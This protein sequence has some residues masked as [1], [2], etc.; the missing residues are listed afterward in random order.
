MT[1]AALAAL[2]LPLL[3]STT[4]GKDKSESTPPAQNAPKRAVLFI[5]ADLRG[6]VAPCGCSENMRGGIAR[7]AEQIARSRKSGAPTFFVE[8]GDSLFGPGPLKEEQLPQEE[9]KARAI[10]QAFQQMGLATRARGELDDARGEAFRTSLQLPELAPGQAKILDSGAGAAKLGVAAGG[11]DAELLQAAKKA[12]DSGATFVLGLYHRPL[13]DAQRLAADPSLQ[14]DLLVATHSDGVDAADN[15]KL[16]QNAGVPVVQLQDKGQVLLRVDLALEGGAARFE[17]IRSSQEVEKEAA[18]LQE[19]IAL[20]NA[21]VNEPGID[22]A[23][24]AMK[25]QKIGELVVRRAVLLSAPP[26]TMEGKNAFSARFVPLDAA[27][28]MDPAVKATVDAY[29]RDVSKLNLEW[30]RAHGKD[31][32]APTAGAPGFAGTARCAE[33]HD[34]SMPV[35]RNSKHSRA[36]ATLVEAGKQ[37][38]LNCIGCHVTGAYQ[39]GGVCRVDKIEGR[40]N[41]GCESCHGPGSVHSED[42]SV[43]NIVRKPEKQACEGCHNHENSPNFDFARYLPQILG[44]GHG[45]PL[46]KKKK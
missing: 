13:A 23:L 11:T 10:A 29:D 20:L 27:L 16:L 6:Y 42:P 1:R 7:A 24:H 40:E 4:C 34:E 2:W 25:Q 28:P 36:Y 41:V 39:P 22:P 31:C 46:A 17:P 32:P 33:C 30:A 26:P 19:R 44:P 21:Q 37:Y 3:A 12:R 15:G 8:G 38:H 43:K 5:A 18:S 9:R 14:A 35:Y 45:Q